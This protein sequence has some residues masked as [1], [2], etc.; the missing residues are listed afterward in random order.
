M[1]RLLRHGLAVLALLLITTPASGRRRARS[2][3][4]PVA[5][6]LRAACSTAR[7][8]PSSSIAR[9]IPR[10]AMPGRRA[11][12]RRS[13]ATA[14]TG[15]TTWRAPQRCSPFLMPPASIPTPRHSPL[16]SRHCA[17]AHHRHRSPAG[18]AT[19]ARLRR[20]SPPQVPAIAA[21][22]SRWRARHWRHHS[23]RWL[24]GGRGGTAGPQRINGRRALPSGRGGP[25]CSP[26][27]AERRAHPVG[28]RHRAGHVARGGTCRPTRQLASRSLGRV[29]PAGEYR[30]PRL[31]MAVPDPTVGSASAVGALL[32]SV[33]WPGPS[34]VVALLQAFPRGGAWFAGPPFS[35]SWHSTATP[36][37]SRG[38]GPRSRIPRCPRWC[39]SP[40]C[41]RW[42]ARRSVAELRALFDGHTPQ[43]LRYGVLEQ[44]R[45]HHD[46]AAARALQEIIAAEPPGEMRDAAKAALAGR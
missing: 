3:T 8:S 15:A 44:L 23:V 20:S 16:G 2:T 28:R 41:S 7:S 6:S 38:S 11:T 45:G 34:T 27:S 1:T 37:S 21:S 33:R 14:A 31:L 42:V 17:R 43:L 10:E 22:P 35:S 19:E 30:A 9:S 46:S 26:A 29:L 18:P 36:K 32:E 4:A 40:G 24:D 12:G 5:T 39:G 13:L 25:G